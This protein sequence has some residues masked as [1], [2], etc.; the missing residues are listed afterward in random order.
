MLHFMFWQFFLL[1]VINFQNFLEKRATQIK[2]GERFSV[3]R[4]TNFQLSEVFIQN[5]PS[6]PSHLV[7][8]LR[9]IIM[10][11]IFSAVI[12]GQYRINKKQNQSHYRLSPL[13]NTCSV[14]TSFLLKNNQISTSKFWFVDT[15]YQLEINPHLKCRNQPRNNYL[16]QFSLFL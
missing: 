8:K 1:P 12:I 2:T 7:S 16:S 14:G 10:L 3:S 5:S 11:I 4:T 6:N 13:F 9:H 15:N